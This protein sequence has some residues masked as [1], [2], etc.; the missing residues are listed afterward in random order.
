MPRTAQL[1]FILCL[2]GTV[3][4]VHAPLLWVWYTHISEENYAVDDV[5]MMIISARH[6]ENFCE[7]GRREES[8]TD[9]K[10]M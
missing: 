3:I 10:K 9:Y 6:I 1:F 4:C 5:M 8:R 7:H 2:L